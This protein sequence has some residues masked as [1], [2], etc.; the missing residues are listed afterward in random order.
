MTVKL[1]TNIILENLKYIKRLAEADESTFRK[2]YE[3]KGE[4]LSSFI[5]ETLFANEVCGHQRD[6]I[7]YRNVVFNMDMQ[8]ESVDTIHIGSIEYLLS[9]YAEL[10]NYAPRITIDKD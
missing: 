4:D 1:S 9:L 2:W 10:S 7:E 6:T 8:A 5:E 3:N